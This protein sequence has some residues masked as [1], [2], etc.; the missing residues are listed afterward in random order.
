[1]TEHLDRDNNIQLLSKYIKDINDCNLLENSIYNYSYIYS[2]QNDLE[3]Y[4]DNIYQDK[5]DE[6]I[7]NINGNLNNNNLLD[8]INNHEI[9]IDNIPYLTPSEIFPENWKDIIKKL[10]LIKDKQENMA[11]TDIFT[12]KK[13]KQNRCTVHQMQTRSADEPMTTF[14]NCIVCNNT[15]KF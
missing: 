9:K 10:E 7:Q 4:K 14:V 5:F 1:M 15:W 2:I 12:C 13:C 8:K 6:I 3:L 11:T